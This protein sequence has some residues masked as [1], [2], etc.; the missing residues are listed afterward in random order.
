VIVAERSAGTTAGYSWPEILPGG[1]SILFTTNDGADAR[2][3][4]LAIRD[5]KTGVDKVLVIGASQ[6]HYVNTGH[7]VYGVVGTLRAVPFDLERHA[8][9]GNAVPVLE[10]VVMKPTGA[11]DF[12]ISRDGL[13]VYV[14]GTSAIAGQTLTWIDRQRHAEATGAPLHNYVTV[15]MSPDGHRLATDIREVD[16]D[17]WIWDLDRKTLSR[18]TFD[19]AAVQ[20][21]SGPRM[22]NGS[23]SVP[24]ALDRC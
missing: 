17:V 12:A 10:R 23:L 18:A 19:A 4:R 20:C 6:G 14:S 15:R 5:L 9:A 21:P 13:L 8:I 7:L 1:T 3:S 22:A 16:N 11:A 2:T 24:T